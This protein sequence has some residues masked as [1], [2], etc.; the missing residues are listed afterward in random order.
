MTRKRFVCSF[1]I[2]VIGVSGVAARADEPVRD[3]GYFLKRLRTLDHLPQLEA[4]HTAM[5]S[6]WDRSGANIDGFDY[7]RIESGGR[8]ILLDVDGPGCIHRI[9]AACQQHSKRKGFVA[10]QRGTRIQIFLDRAAKPILDMTLNDFFIF[11]KKTP[12]PYPLVFEKSYPGCLHPIPFAKH[13][14]VQLVNPDYKKADAKKREWWGGWWQIT[15]T[16]YAKQVKVKTLEYPLSKALK[17]EQDAVVRTWLKAE[18]SPPAAPKKWSVDRTVVV[19][20]GKSEEIRLDGTGVIRQLRL[21]VDDSSPESLKALRLEMYWDGSKAP[22]VDVPV[23]YFFGHANTG[24]NTIHK[25]PGV[26]PPGKEDQPRG[27][28]F[29]YSCN[30]NSLLIG[31]LPTEAYACFP[32]PFAKGAVLRLRNTRP[33]K[34]VKVKIKLDIQNRKTLPRNWGRFHATFTEERSHGAKSVK[35]GPKKIPSKIVLQRQ[36]RGKYIGALIHVDWPS[37]GWWGEGDWL[38]WS[39]EN[40]WPPSYHGTGSEEYFQGGGGQFDRKAI[41]GFVTERPGH[42][43]VYSFHLN[44]AF[45]FQKS[46]RIAQE[47]VGFGISFSKKHPIWSS[48]AFWYAESALPARSGDVLP[49]K[50]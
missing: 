6:T 26:M 49:D 23:G 14:L 27:K 47:Q 4:S 20:A 31:V 3:V 44:D 48:T 1:V 50:D 12:F 8:N 42:P 19:G 34:T 33:G 10:D 21:A 18:S 46:I 43:T 17:L 11:R 36:A 25:S 41:S 7:K 38:I 22:S 37:S 32:M 15:Y 45:Q 24:H 30:F 16:S 29:K 5:S 40:Q 28:V 2:M 39:D 13:C 35:L 9:M